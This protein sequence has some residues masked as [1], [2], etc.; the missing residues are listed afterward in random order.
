M[1]EDAPLRHAVPVQLAHG[2]LLEV[3]L[4]SGNVLARREIRYD[5]QQEV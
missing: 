3:L 1:R 2:T 5:L 4:R